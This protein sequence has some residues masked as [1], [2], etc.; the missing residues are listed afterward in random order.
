MRVRRRRDCTYPHKAQKAGGVIAKC[1]Q[2][3]KKSLVVE[4]M[5]CTAFK[6]W[7]MEHI[8]GSKFITIPQSST[9]EYYKVSTC[10]RE[11]DAS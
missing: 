10:I 6:N 7:E 8:E 5:H 11:F 3:V 4:N 1:K 2:L 9:M